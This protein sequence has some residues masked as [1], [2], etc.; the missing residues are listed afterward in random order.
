MLAITCR[1]EAIQ[2]TKKNPGKAW[3]LEVPNKTEGG[4]ENGIKV[5]IKKKSLILHKLHYQPTEGVRHLF[6]FWRGLTLHSGHGHF[7]EGGNEEMSLKHF[8]MK[9]CI[10]NIIRS[11]FSQCHLPSLYHQPLVPHTT[12]PHLPLTSWRKCADICI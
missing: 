2:F 12:T 11:P 7:V 1:Q 4:C 10:V 5:S 3:T 8:C 6:Y 9:V